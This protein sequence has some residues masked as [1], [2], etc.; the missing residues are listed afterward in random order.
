MTH[1][2]LFDELTIE[3]MESGDFIC[4][5]DKKENRLWPIEIDALWTQPKGNSYLFMIKAH[6]G[7]DFFYRQ[8]FK[9]EQE[10]MNYMTSVSSL[11]H[12]LGRKKIERQL[13]R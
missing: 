2:R 9:T 5:I 10:A 8:A 6:H 1:K 11:M 3:S 13:R 12:E 4:A 7:D